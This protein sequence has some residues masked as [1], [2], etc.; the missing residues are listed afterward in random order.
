MCLLLDVPRPRNIALQ[1]DVDVALFV[2][3]SKGWISLGGQLVAEDNAIF[4]EMW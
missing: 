4:G 3:L 2:T 1:V